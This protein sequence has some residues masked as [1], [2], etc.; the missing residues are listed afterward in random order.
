MYILCGIV[1][2]CSVRHEKLKKKQT[3]TN[4][5]GGYVRR[6]QTACSSIACIIYTCFYMNCLTNMYVYRERK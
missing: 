5:R 2:L 6:I 1:I 3:A 4:M